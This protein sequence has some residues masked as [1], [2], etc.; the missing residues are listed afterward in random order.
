L[1]ALRSHFFLI[2]ICDP[3]KAGFS[4]LLVANILF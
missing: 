4:W 2:E 3:G 1:R